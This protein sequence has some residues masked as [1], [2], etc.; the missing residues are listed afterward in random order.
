METKNMFS[1]FSQMIPIWEE[2]QSYLFI[3]HL[4]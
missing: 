1:E 3:Y 4:D 2:K